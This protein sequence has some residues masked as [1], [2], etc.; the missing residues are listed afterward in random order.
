MHR[1]AVENIGKI[2]LTRWSNLWVSLGRVS[3]KSRFLSDSIWRS[4]I[5]NFT[6]I[7]QNPRILR[8]EDQLRNRIK[9]NCHSVCLLRH[10]NTEFHDNPMNGLRAATMWQTVRG[11]WSSHRRSFICNER[12]WL[13]HCA[14]PLTE[15]LGGG[16]RKNT[17][18]TL[19]FCL[20]VKH[21][22]LSQASLPYVILVIFTARWRTDRVTLI[23]F[24]WAGFL[25][26]RGRWN[27][28]LVDTRY[29]Y[30]CRCCQI[31]Y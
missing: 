26:S 20:F 31:G 10:C 1:V 19:P 12:L 7:F 8:Q 14:F 11:T 18:L 13:F 17:C 30:N 25:K 23:F 27:W 15:K 9:Y 2:S 16:N 22:V 3:Q 4:Y 28:S 6:H 21:S 5:Q 29:S 24:G